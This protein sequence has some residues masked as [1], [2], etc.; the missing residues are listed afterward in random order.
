M[1]QH[2]PLYI[3]HNIMIEQLCN[4]PEVHVATVNWVSYQSM[5]ENTNFL[6]MIQALNLN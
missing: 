2:T 5:K 3:D 1:Q 6:C 4:Q